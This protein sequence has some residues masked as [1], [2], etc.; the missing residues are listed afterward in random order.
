M[1]PPGAKLG[2]GTQ[3]AYALIREHVPFIERDALLYGARIW[4]RRHP[5]GARSSIMSRP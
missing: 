1:R 5:R 3:A 4:R 2:R